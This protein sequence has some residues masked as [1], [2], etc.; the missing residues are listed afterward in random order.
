MS[1]THGNGTLVRINGE[2]HPSLVVD[3]FRAMGCQG[4]LVV[5]G[6]TTAHVALAR[7][8]LEHLESRWSRFRPESDISRINRACGIA[9]PVDPA[10]I[11]LVTAMVHAW[12]VTER[13]FDPTLLAPLIGLGHATSWDDPAR[14]TSL[15]PMAAPRGRPYEIAVDLANSTIVAPYGTVLDAGG[16]GKGL[17][18]DRVASE[19]IEAGADGVLVN[20]G[21]DLRVAGHPPQG[22][23]GWQIAVGSPYADDAD[24]GDAECARVAIAEGGVAT[25]GTT[26]R[27]WTTADGMNVHH[28]LDPATLMPVDTSRSGDGQSGDG[29]SEVVQVTVAA[30][31]AM[32]AEVHT[33]SVLVH[34]A[35]RELPRFDAIGLA[36][37]VVLA[38]GRTIAN[39]SWN[40][41]AVH[42]DAS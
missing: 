26:R 7:R 33:K 1:T 39:Q 41:L 18:A 19:L 20:I 35:K 8:L 31:S 6:G 24:G 38:D 12:V 2:D 13:A 29:V 5:V 9:V 11:E 22:E 14:V 25:S 32:W 10:T 3:R 36:A 27:R 4:G 40:A 16:I 23:L 37:M 28:V 30:S 34:G 15:P 21:G 17:A 42:S